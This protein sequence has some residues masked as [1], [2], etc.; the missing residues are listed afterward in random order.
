MIPLY[1][2]VA[3]DTIGLLVLADEDDTIAEVARKLQSAARLRVAPRTAVDLIRGGQVLDPTVRVR[4]AGFA[5]LDRIDVVPRS[6]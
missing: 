1:G 3:G 2:F 6:P 5:P 4:A